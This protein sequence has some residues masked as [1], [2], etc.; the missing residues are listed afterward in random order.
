VLGHLRNHHNARIFHVTQFHF[1]SIKPN[2]G[3]VKIS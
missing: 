1:F 2:F 3:R